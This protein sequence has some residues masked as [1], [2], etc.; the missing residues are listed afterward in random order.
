MKQEGE[1][2]GG[3]GGVGAYLFEY[4][5]CPRNIPRLVC[6][7]KQL[8]SSRRRTTCHYTVRVDRIPNSSEAGC[9][10]PRGESR[11]ADRSSSSSEAYIFSALETKER[12][13]GDITIRD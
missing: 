9:I 6:T 5:T 12:G 1:D 2:R 8:Y 3:G 10:R 7:Y 11:A 4:R 13:R